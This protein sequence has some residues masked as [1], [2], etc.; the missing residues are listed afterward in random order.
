M[1]YKCNDKWSK[2]HLCPNQSL[3]VLIMVNGFEIEFLDSRRGEIEEDTGGELMELSL[4]SFLGIFP[5]TTT[6]MKGTI[7][8]HHIMV[9]LDSGVTHNFIAL[10]VVQRTHLRLRENY[11]VEGFIV[12]RRLCERFGGLQKCSVWTA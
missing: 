7:K 8:K 4:N 5:P 2:T 1:C 6:K 9:M 10:S 12:E 3:Q 11:S